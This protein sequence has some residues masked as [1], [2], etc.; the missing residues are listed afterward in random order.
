MVAFDDR[1]GIVQRRGD[2]RCSLREML[3]KIEEG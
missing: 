1:D 3:K 2:H